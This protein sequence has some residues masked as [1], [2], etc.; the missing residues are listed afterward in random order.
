MSVFVTTAMAQTVIGGHRL[1]IGETVRYT[2]MISFKGNGVSGICVLKANEDGFVGTLVNEFGIKAMDF[3]YQ[4][5]N[6]NVKLLNVIKFLD[7][8]YIR[9]IVRKDLSHLFSAKGSERLKHRN[10][11]IGENG[12]MSLENTKYHITYNLIPIHENATTE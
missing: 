4:S 7:K 3:V 12:D 5:R 11:T 8:W 10:I 9:K 6:R 1:D 2:S